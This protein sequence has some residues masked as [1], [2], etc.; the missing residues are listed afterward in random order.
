M[1]KGAGSWGWV[2]GLVSSGTGSS[3]APDVGGVGGV[4][5]RG[6]AGDIPLMMEMPAASGAARPVRTSCHTLRCREGHTLR[7]TVAG[8]KP[9]CTVPAVGRQSVPR[10]MVGT[11]ANRGPV[12]LGSPT[13]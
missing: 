12:P 5:N 4:E 2:A 13:E 10:W 1:E 7:R 8:A 3:G 9:A 6:A 11:P